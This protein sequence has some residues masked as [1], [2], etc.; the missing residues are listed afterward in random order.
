MFDQAIDDILITL[1]RTVLTL[2]HPNVTQT[3]DE[4]AALVKSVNQ[5]AV[6]AGKSNDARVAELLAEL[7]AAVNLHL[8]RRLQ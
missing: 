7:E 8:P 1:G 3:A 6:C 4:K 5:F 2:A